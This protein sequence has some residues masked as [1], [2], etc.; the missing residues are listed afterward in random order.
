MGCGC[1][2]AV[3]HQQGVLRF[4]GGWSHGAA[5]HQLNCRA[6]L[7][8]AKWTALEVCAIHF[9]W[10]F[11][12]PAWASLLAGGTRAISPRPARYWGHIVGGPDLDIRHHGFG[13]VLLPSCL[14][15]RA[16]ATSA[17]PGL[18]LYPRRKLGALPGCGGCLDAALSRLLMPRVRRIELLCAFV[19]VSL[20]ELRSDVCLVVMRVILWRIGHA[21]IAH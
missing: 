14:H 4:S 12:Q 20:R 11:C 7:A 16:H 3:V 6:F 1:S 18:A 5:R 15:V 2:Q 17:I 9:C 19:S 13:L 8:V 10:C 21:S